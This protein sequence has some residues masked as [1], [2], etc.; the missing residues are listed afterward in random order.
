MICQCETTP[1]ADGWYRHH[2]QKCGAT[3][4]LRRATVT[5]IECK[6]PG[7]DPMPKQRPKLSTTG[8]HLHAIFRDGFHQ[9]FTPSCSCRKT[10]EDMNANPPEWSEA[11]RPMIVA[12]IKAEMKNRGWWGKILFHVPGVAKPLNYIVKEAI[13]RAKK[14]ALNGKP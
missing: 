13:R 2:C 12:K 9:D 1:L 14:D 4:F 6:E 10:M 11:N 8:D 5:D 3:Y 7:V